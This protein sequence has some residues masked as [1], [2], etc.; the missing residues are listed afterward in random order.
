MESHMEYKYSHMRTPC[1]Y[2]VTAFY[3][4]F[5]P[6]AVRGFSKR[7]PESLEVIKGDLFRLAEAHKIQGLLVL[8]PEGINSTCAA[9]DPEDL[10]NFKQALKEYFSLSDL[11]FKDSQSEIRPFKKYLIKI[12]KEIVTAGLP[13]VLPPERNFHLSPKEWNQ[14]LEE[15]KDAVLIDTRNWYEHKIGTFK[16]S[17]NPNIE[18]FTEF[19]DYLEKQKISKDKKLLIFCTGGI[20]CEKGILELQK[21]GYNNVHQLEG[22]ILKYLEEYPDRNFEGECFVFDHR[23][24]LDQ[25]LRPS[26]KYGL[27]PHCGQPAH[28]FIKCKRC[29]HE[30]QV[31]ELCLELPFKKETCSKN[32]AYQYKLHPERKAPRVK[33]PA[34]E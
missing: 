2:S 10:K 5:D 25:K 30:T 20:R 9:K 31:C 16:G 1:K 24:A 3:H 26:K 14:T 22:G 29:D 18:K 15:D 12:R 27:C 28:T 17:L 19:P 23:V 6:M 34:K 7:T 13:G 32:C 33:P 4:F 11:N 8:G 21:K